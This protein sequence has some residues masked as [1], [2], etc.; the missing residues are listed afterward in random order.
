MAEPLEVEVVAADR[1]VWEGRA[2]NVIVRT[3]E[4][5][6][7]ILPRHEALL[8]GLVPCAVEIVTDQGS[9]DLIAV[10]G[11]FVAVSDN[12][13]SILTQ[14]ATLQAEISREAAQRE[15][16]Q[17]ERVKEAGEM[18]DDDLH[19][20]HLAQAQLRVADRAGSGAH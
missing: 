4:G 20:Y 16:D 14:Q 12:R 17:F 3:T 15:L 13:V 8:A 1:L 9:R 18:D 7:G 11:G 19:R 2:T 5:D 10:E 6:L